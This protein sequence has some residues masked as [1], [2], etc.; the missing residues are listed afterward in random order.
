MKKIKFILP[1]VL[2][3]SLV[4]VGAF[5]DNTK[6]FY[7]KV[8]KRAIPF[9]EKLQDF[10]DIE[11]GSD[12]GYYDDVDECLDESMEMEEK[13]YTSCMK[14]NDEDREECDEL[15]EEY[16]DT[17]SEML[18]KDGCEDFYKGLQC[19]YA[20]DKDECEEEVEGLCE[21]LPKNF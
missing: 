6:S 20:S 2:L 19:G 18:T 21:D 9:Q 1:L 15:T 4:L 5:C 16:R 3:A 12:F 17:I 10:Y 7:K 14:E 8:C 11:G 13:M